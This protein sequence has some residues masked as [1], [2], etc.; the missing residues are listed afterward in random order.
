MR[1]DNAEI[2]AVLKAG[3]D[4]RLEKLRHEANSVTTDADRLDVYFGPDDLREALP[5]G[6]WQALEAQGLVNDDTSV[7]ELFLTVYGSDSIRQL[8]DNFRQ[9]GF[10]DVPTDWAGGAATISWLRKMGFGA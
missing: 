1:L 6:L 8:Q 10:P 3:L 9:L 2:S 5:S 4:H 7:A